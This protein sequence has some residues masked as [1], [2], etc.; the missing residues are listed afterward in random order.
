MTFQLLYQFVGQQL[1]ERISIWRRLQSQNWL[2]S[3]SAR[4]CGHRGFPEPE[5]DSSA[6][7]SGQQP[8]RSIP[9][10]QEDQVAKLRGRWK[11]RTGLQNTENQW[12]LPEG[13]QSKQVEMTQYHTL[14]TTSLKLHSMGQKPW[15]GTE[16]QYKNQELGA[17]IANAMKNIQKS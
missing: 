10:P 8:H 16:L 12:Q 14:E 4:G 3:H 11:R 2:L 17:E 6:L 13:E 15:E 5:A 7:N 1:L 9:S